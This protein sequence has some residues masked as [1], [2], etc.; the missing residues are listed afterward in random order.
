M[1]DRKARRQAITALNTAAL[2]VT[3]SVLGISLGG[4]FEHLPWW[5]IW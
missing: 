2:A 4:L 1:G 3:F 5:L